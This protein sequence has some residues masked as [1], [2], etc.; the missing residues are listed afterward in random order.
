MRYDPTD[1]III[2]QTALL[3]NRLYSYPTDCI[4]IL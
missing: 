2:Q 1:C 4:I 3:S